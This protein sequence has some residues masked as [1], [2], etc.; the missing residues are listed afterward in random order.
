MARMLKIIAGLFVA[1]MLLGMINYGPAAVG[2]EIA[3]AAQNAGA[4]G[5]RFADANPAL[6]RVMLLVA[7][8][9]VGA[10]VIVKASRG[11]AASWRD[12]ALRRRLARIS[13]AGFSRDV[14]MDDGQVE[15]DGAIYPDSR[16]MRFVVEL[17]T[18][19]V[20]GGDVP[21]VDVVLTVQRP[22]GSIASQLRQPASPSQ[23]KRLCAVFELPD[24]SM[25]HAAP[26]DW[27][28][29]A[30]LQPSNRPLAVSTLRVF[31]PGA[32]LQDLEACDLKLTT[33]GGAP[34]ELSNVIFN[35][36]DGISVSAVVRP[37]TLNPAHLPKLAARF[38]LVRCADGSAV[39]LGQRDLEFVN[40]VAM[41]GDV[42]TAVAGA[43][44][45][46]GTGRWDL[47]VAVGEHVLARLPLNLVSPEE[48]LSNLRVE[49]FDL[50]AMRGDALAGTLDT[51]AC[52]D[53]VDS[54]VPIVQIGSRFPSATQ[55]FRVTVGVCVGSEVIGY[56]EEQLP[57]PYT[58]N[59][60]VLGELSLSDRRLNG[61][62]TFFVIVNERCLAQR[63]LRM[64]PRLPAV[65]DVQGRLRDSIN[66]P[67]DTDAEAARILAEATVV[68]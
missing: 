66:L 25:L 24:L 36:I 64:V 3:N 21:P 29:Q 55:R 57:L 28:I 68:R 52:G 16:S 9:A 54:I 46:S 26:G 12:S 1:G 31:N 5:H 51:T 58:S 41:I 53:S 65:S 8:I 59:Q 30:N 20:S 40:G 27:K 7:G 50:C 37:H 18:A 33:A 63:E 19:E 67:V 35:N 23:F 2:R 17:S 39:H 62:C 43:R 11:I 61:P 47:V 48:V 14:T 60:V 49:R 42:G 4:W 13:L 34:L 10:G 44:W 22:D 6:A 32:M 38:V 45:A 56:V 15:T